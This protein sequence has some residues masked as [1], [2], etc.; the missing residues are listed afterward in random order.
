MCHGAISTH[1][2]RCD[3][4]SCFPDFDWSGRVVRFNICDR[5]PLAFD[6]DEIRAGP[7]A[8]WYGKTDAK[9]RN[10]GS[11]KRMSLIVYCA[12]W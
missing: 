3:A 5:V 10:S 9:L 11:K 8:S 2:R 7:V 1:D 6:E 4:L 12:V